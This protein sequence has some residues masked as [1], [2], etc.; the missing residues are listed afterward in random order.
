MCIYLNTVAA[1]KSHIYQLRVS[2]WH[3]LTNNDILYPVTHSRQKT[4]PHSSTKMEWKWLTGL[5]FKVRDSLIPKVVVIKPTYTTVLV[6]TQFWLT[7]GCQLTIDKW[8]PLELLQSIPCL[9]TL[10]KECTISCIL[11][12]VAWTS[13]GC[14]PLDLLN[15][16]NLQH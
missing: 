11:K 4:T 15:E 7:G 13:A 12:W 2:M 5:P 1:S 9:L 10:L 3:L 16:L 14:R 8:T 6:N